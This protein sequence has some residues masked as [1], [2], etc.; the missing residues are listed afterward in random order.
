MTELF[1]AVGNMHIHT[2][3]SD[4]QK[5]HREVA[6]DAARAGLDFI[7]VT[8]HNVWVHGVE[9]YYEFDEGRVLLL[10]GEEVHDVRRQP[11]ANH[12]L[13]YGAQK[14]MSP[15]AS[16]PQKLID[17]TNKAGGCGFLA[18]PYERD[19]PVFNG[20]ALG[21]YAWEVKSYTGLEIWNYMSSFKNELSRKVDSLA[22]K[23]RLYAMAHIIRMALHPERHIVGPEP[24]VLE[25]WDEL[26][27][28]GRRI[29]AIGNSDA[30]G[31]PM[32]AGP[33]TRTIFPYEFLFRAVNTHVL[34]PTELNGDLEHDRALIMG[35]IGRGNAW[36]G[37]DMA[38][39]TRGF[40][41][42]GHGATKGIMG[43]E[44]KLDGGATLQIMAP[45]RASIRPSSDRET[46]FPAQ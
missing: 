24:Q 40:R 29:V 12:F 46:T 36:V 28:E 44:I 39:P 14:E 9:G 8:D 13:V 35:A 3:Y 4:G 15:Y 26:L 6:H 31:S 22:L 27:A 19:L 20:H 1:E 45:A 16:D 41:F 11:Q 34:T 43:D 38:H 37:Y 25:K 42:S 33:L 21:W 2:P 18:H 23:H 30:H 10:T 17:E 7:I 32:S 5:W